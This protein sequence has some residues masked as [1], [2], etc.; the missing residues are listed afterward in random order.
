MR[1]LVF[2]PIRVA[3]HGV[4]PPCPGVDSADA[5]GD[6]VSDR[7]RNRSRWHFTQLHQRARVDLAEHRRLSERKGLYLVRAGRHD[8]SIIGIGRQVLVVV[9]DLDSVEGVEGQVPLAVDVV[10][11]RQVA[12]GL[13][14]EDGHRA[15]PG[16]GVEARAV[17]AHRHR[18]D[19]GEAPEAA[20]VDLDLPQNQVPVASVV[21]TVELDADTVADRPG[22]QIDANAAGRSVV[23]PWHGGHVPA[24][25][26][27]IAVINDHEE[28]GELVGIVGSVEELHVGEIV[29]PTQ[30]HLP[31]GMLVIL[32]VGERVGVVP[33]PPGVLVPVHG[34]IGSGVGEV[35]KCRGL[36]RSLPKGD[37]RRGG[38]A[39]RLLEGQGAAPRA[40]EAGQRVLSGAHGVERVAEE[41]DVRDALEA[42]SDG[43]GFR[44]QANV[45]NQET[46]FELIVQY[47]DDSHPH[48]VAA[49]L[50]EGVVEAGE[51]RLLVEGRRGQPEDALRVPQHLR[52]RCNRHEREVVIDNVRKVLVRQEV[53]VERH[54][55]A[56]SERGHRLLDRGAS[57]H[58]IAQVVQ[59]AGV[60]AEEGLQL[61]PGD[62]ARGVRQQGLVAALRRARAVGGRLDR[63]HTFRVPAGEIARL[64]ALEPVDRD[65][66]GLAVDDRLEEAQLAGL[67]V[68]FEDGEGVVGR[69][70]H[71]DEA[72]VVADDD[73]R[74]AVEGI[75]A[76]EAVLQDLHQVQHAP[77]AL[78]EHRH[79]VVA[80]AG[81]IDEVPE[82]GDVRDAVESAEVGGEAL[83]DEVAEAQDRG[84]RDQL[85]P[86]AVDRDPAVVHLR[87]FQRRGAPLAG[88]DANL[89]DASGREDRV[90]PGVENFRPFLELPGDL[91]RIGIG[92]VVRGQAV[93]DDQGLGGVAQVRVQ[94]VVFGIHRI[95]GDLD[96]DLVIPLAAMDS[97]EVSHLLHRDPV[98]T[99]VALD[100]EQ[101]AGRRDVDRQS[102]APGAER[103]AD[104]VDARHV[105][106]AD[107][108]PEVREVEGLL[109]ADAVH[110]LALES[111]SRDPGGLRCRIEDDPVLTAPEVEVRA[112]QGAENRDLVAVRIR[113]SDLEPGL[114][115]SLLEALV[116]DPGAGRHAEPA[117]PVRLHLACLPEA[118]R[119]AVVVVAE[120][121][122]VSARAAVEDEPPLDVT[123]LV[124]HLDLVLAGAGLDRDH[125]SSRHLGN[126]DGVVVASRGDLDRVGVDQSQDLDAAARAGIGVAVI[127]E[128]RDGD[129]RLDLATSGDLDIVAGAQRHRPLGRLD[130]GTV[131]QEQVVTGIRR[132]LHC[133]LDVTQ[134]RAHRRDIQRAV[135]LLQ[136][137]ALP[138]GGRERRRLDLQRIFG[139]GADAAVLRRQDEIRTLQA[140][141]ARRL[142]DAAAGG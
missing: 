134:G 110:V 112:D 66:G 130:R 55:H 101:G 21:L 76:A 117:D 131:T 38:V 27:G 7:P 33:M 78:L 109:A 95:A 37:V 136:V 40:H 77:C 123:Q 91:L 102:I 54:L 96:H 67:R 138:S 85:E 92:R 41:G 125:G 26:L 88:E 126:A 93:V 94:R 46:G 73:A 53:P 83:V 51:P 89:V 58:P 52:G 103:H 99:A 18:V 39:D 1:T 56:G 36:R 11:E 60:E 35:L 17:L 15:V 135:D 28:V 23:R 62:A 48:D 119:V 133:E 8:D 100:V 142:L 10:E 114:G 80:G 50:L 4:F 74:R 44:R 65:R 2:D 105:H 115:G 120:E 70:A 129:P 111:G 87:H 90:F 98:V 22:R 13:A 75:H 86:V 140:E 61:A 59:G 72:A 97:G 20:G 25:H 3:Q 122:A 118:A 57:G 49:G 104:L 32:R 124:A 81:G 132:V 116:L 64:E 12:V 45:V 31:P 68:A 29:I 14:V 139:G 106:V 34:T 107:D 43:D 84:A 16:G 5:P 69:C 63:C 30:I 47:V 19:A 113:E 42:V 79:R 108:R 24:K 128:D 137:D 71:V 6:R 121:Q 127:P 82:A 9:L 141:E